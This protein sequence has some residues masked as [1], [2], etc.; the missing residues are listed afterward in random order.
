MAV[1]VVEVLPVAG[2]KVADLAAAHAHPTLVSRARIPATDREAASQHKHGRHKRH[3]TAAMSSHAHRETNSAASPATTS[4][5]SSPPAMRRQDFRLRVS[6]AAAIAATS[7]ADALVVPAVV[8]AAAGVATA[9][10]VAQAAR[11][12]LPDAEP[13]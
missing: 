3:A 13:C 1:V 11:V 12:R 10:R 8:V 9:D 7:G 4:T 5:T 6:P 2:A